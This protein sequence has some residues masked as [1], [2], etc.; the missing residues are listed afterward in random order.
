MH[1]LTQWRMQL[2][3]Q[4]L[5]SQA[6]PVSVLAERVGYQSEAAFSRAFKRCLGC[7]PSEWRAG[8][9]AVH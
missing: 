2:A 7:A 9:S 6:V 4:T 3:A 5:D 1:Y 8:R